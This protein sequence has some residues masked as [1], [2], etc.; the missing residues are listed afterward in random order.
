M[1]FLKR[2]SPYLAPYSIDEHRHTK[3]LR[4]T[5]N[6]IKSLSAF[7]IEQFRND[8]GW[9]N[10]CAGRGLH[11]ARNNLAQCNDLCCSLKRCPR[12]RGTGLQTPS[13]I[14]NPLRSI[15]E[16]TDKSDLTGF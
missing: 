16:T 3:K 4:K 10:L 2:C 12:A 15:P 14:K 11:G 1:P 9:R 5:F 13:S 7:F 6:L 8:I